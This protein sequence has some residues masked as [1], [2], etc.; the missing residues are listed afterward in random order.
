LPTSKDC[1][2]QEFWEFAATWIEQHARGRNIILCT[3][4]NATLHRTDDTSVGNVISSSANSP[5]EAFHMFLERT[6]I[7]V[8]STFDAFADWHRATS[9]PNCG[10]ELA[11]GRRV[12]FVGGG[13]SVGAMTQSAVVWEDFVMPHLHVD[14]LPVAVNITVKLKPHTTHFRRKRAGYDRKATKNLVKRAHF[15]RLVAEIPSPL[16]Q[17][18][19]TTHTYVLDKAINHA[20]ITAFG[21][22]APVQP[23]QSYV[24]AST[25]QLIKA[26]RMAMRQAAYA[27]MLLRG[28]PFIS[29]WRLFAPRMRS[30]SLRAAFSRSNQSCHSVF[31]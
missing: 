17:F 24:T 23:K 1:S 2:I 12:D 7:W 20:A 5:S 19:P 30:S 9:F 28:G 29:F 10:G 8:P 26:R 15:Q 3:D 4:A 11:V 6:R 22:P 25:M 27:G 18:E 13:E 14:H 16:F 31:V 21:T